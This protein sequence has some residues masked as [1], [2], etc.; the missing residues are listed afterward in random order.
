MENIKNSFEDSV[1]E[2][3]SI[4]NRKI[5]NNLLNKFYET[6][7]EISDSPTVIFQDSTNLCVFVND[8]FC[9]RTGILRDAILGKK[10]S[11]VAINAKD[12]PSHLDHINETRKLGDATRKASF[13]LPDGSSIIGTMRSKI[14]TYNGEN[15]RVSIASDE[16]KLQNATDTIQ[17]NKEKY[18]SIF[19]SIQDMIFLL[20]LEDE[21]GQGKINIVNDATVRI[22]GFSKEEII[23]KHPSFF[24]TE[25]DKSYINDI[26]DKIDSGESLTMTREFLTKKGKKIPLEFKV[27]PVKINGK[28]GVICIAR[29]ISDSLR[30]KNELLFQ[31]K[32]LKQIMNNATET[33]CTLDESGTIKSWSKSSEKVHGFPA[34]KIIGQNI[35]N[36]DMDFFSPDVEKLLIILRRAAKRQV[37]EQVE[38][39]YI[40][41]KGASRTVSLNLSP[42]KNKEGE[43][44]G[45]IIIGHDITEKRNISNKINHGNA[46]LACDECASSI[47]ESLINIENHNI[48]HF[49]RN[50]PKNQSLMKD[51]ENV[52]TIILSEIDEGN[53]RNIQSLDKFYSIIEEF[54][55]ENQN[56]LRNIILLDRFDYLTT[57]FGFTNALRC[58]YKISDLI[59]SYNSILVVHTKEEYYLE[60][61][62]SLLVSEFLEFPKKELEE[63]KLDK[64]KFELL[65]FVKEKNEAHIEVPYNLIGKAFNLSKMTTK[66]WIINLEEK[67]LLLIRKDGRTKY[68]YIT[69]KARFLLGKE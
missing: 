66:R 11:D 51:E 18:E 7:F 36:T 28:P 61:E 37:S 53:N 26:R 20:T 34:S 39:S 69:E 55:K 12:V 30:S 35:F 17:E 14:I 10:M 16:T 32:I 42:I 62:F 65:E 1:I 3:N 6:T 56:P 45:L 63:I 22:M 29:D 58:L 38:L 4:Y 49:T 44:K 46:Y 25:E 60:T 54:V 50:N 67:G 5:H 24:D 68:I 13:R 52:K 21:P 27:K 31:N 59:K 15:Y 57:R 41:N 33:I 9:K 40:T 43:Y 64:E 8:E 23:G 47:Q 19:N 2:E 48:L